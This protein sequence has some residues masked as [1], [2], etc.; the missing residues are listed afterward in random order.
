MFAILPAGQ[1]IC[2]QWVCRIKFGL[3]LK[4]FKVGESRARGGK[5]LVALGSR[6]LSSAGR[7]RDGTERDHTDRRGAFPTDFQD[8]AVGV[9]AGV[10]VLGPGH[11]LQQKEAPLTKVLGPGPASHGGAKD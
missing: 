8:A 2:S 4:S 6:D 7:L 1:P 11:L 10:E 5:S 9:D 3:D